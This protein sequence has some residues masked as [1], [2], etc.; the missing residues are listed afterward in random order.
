MSMRRSK[1]KGKG[2]IFGYVAIIAGLVMILSLILPY[3][4]WWFILGACLIGFGI[5]INKRC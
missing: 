1:G 2:N 3:R 5:F 4:F